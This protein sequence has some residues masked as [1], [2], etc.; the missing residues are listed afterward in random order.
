MTGGTAD[1]TPDRPEK[2]TG[3]PEEALRSEH[4]TTRPPPQVGRVTVAG[5]LH[6]G[7]TAARLRGFLDVREGGPWDEQTE[8]RVRHDLEVLG[9]SA[10]IELRGSELHVAVQPMR[11]VRR[12]Y[13]TGNWPIFEW[14][15]LSYVTWRA[16]FRLP[17]AETLAGEIRKQEQELIGFL[18]RKGYYD[19]SARLQLDWAPDKPGQ[20]DVHIRVSLNVG[21]WRLR[22]PIGNIK[23]EGFSLLSKTELQGF[24]EHCCLWFGRTSTERINEDFK[25][26]T[27]F[28]QQK[29]YA[30]VRLLRRE[31]QPDRQRKRVDLDIAIDERRRIQLDF[32]G[33]KEVPENDLRGAV[34]IFRDNYYSSNELDESARNI[35]RLYQQQGFFEARVS[36]RWKRRTSDDMHHSIKDAP[37]EVEFLIHE[38][39]QLKVRDID[40]VSGP[41]GA[42]L[43]YSAAKLAEQ[44][45]TRRYPRLGLIGLGEGGFA[46]AIQLEQDVH[47]LEEFY[48]REGYPS[49]RVAVSVARTK[50]ALDSAALLGLQTASD[51]KIG[52][53]ALFLRFRIDEGQRETVEAVSIRLTA[54]RPDLTEAQ[55]RK[56]LLLR[57][58]KPYTPESLEAD[59]QRLGELFSAEGH[60]YADIDPTASTWNADH[61]RVTLRWV[62]DEREV[63]RFGPILIRG[64]FVTQDSV[65]RSDIPFKAGD[66]YDRNKLLE[67][68]QNLLGRQI[69][70]TVRV[71]PNP[72]ESDDY[73]AE[74]R[75]RG[76][77]LTRNPVPI[78]VEVIERYDSKGEI[79]VYVGFSTDNPV[80]STGSY[81]WRNFLGLGAEAE[82]R[83]DLGV[84][85]QS[86]LARISNPRLG[87]R[88]LRLDVRGFWRNEN[89]YSVGQ[90]TSYGANAELTRSFARP[91]DQGRR[92]S[93]TLRLFTRLEFNISQILVPLTREELSG[94]VGADGDRTQ[95][96]KLSAGVVWDRRVGFEAPALRLR[97]L[98]V[99]PNPLMPVSGFLLSAQVT[100]SMC[101]S[102]APFNGLGSFVAFAAQAVVL[103][104]F[105]PE[106]RPE[107]GWP[108]GM[109][110]FNFKLNLRVNYGI[111]FFR[112]GL[113]VVERY[114]AGGDSSTRGYDADALRAQEVRTP[115]GPLTGEPAYRV[116]PLGG[117]VRILSQ[118]EWEFAITPKLLSWP[119]VG[120]VF[121]DTGAVFD[122]WDKLQWN[123]V[124]FSLGVSLFRLLTQFGA[125]SL[126]YAY[127]LTMPG[128]DPLLQSD[129]WKREPWYS[130]FPGRIHF[131]WGMPISL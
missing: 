75:S 71:T 27:D 108:Y 34:T 69:F 40:F 41:G 82:L 126:D 14:E 17:D 63:V 35:Y 64:N 85:V 94:D 21:F 118:L 95:S 5:S 73:R 104:P 19:A 66:R 93:P 7:D 92:L 38:G 89:T 106:L 4:D 122:G 49:A 36:W 87:S 81:T 47:R 124:R 60:P 128:Q 39:P 105:G 24:F 3:G 130:H 125:L 91:D 98:P 13:V 45:S 84:R 20:V 120:A 88:F 99:P 131:N 42:P 67:A 107:D 16:G 26:L 8:T 46:S 127:P 113:P 33:R 58:G 62:I 115:L 9:Y 43:S 37:L 25:R 61:S 10:K 114:F 32:I 12:I 117:N 121:L 109:R 59:K 79:G 100:A 15:I 48:R 86:L 103:K 44:V 83:G 65:I 23:A 52:E 56:V 70:S 50:E 110:R 76:W 55:V 112:P 77:K 123:D 18:Q 30:G 111:P 31:I 102:F 29:G 11:V 129:R 28:Y 116:V 97:N 6:P 51:E 68:Q 80:Y 119:W 2:R 1:R 53:D 74:A 101:C 54:D 96:L 57:A 22:Y 72:G 78:L 90:V